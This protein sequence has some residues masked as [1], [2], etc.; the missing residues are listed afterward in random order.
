[1]VTKEE[2]EAS[3]SA[4][5]LWSYGEQFLNASKKLGTPHLPALYLACHGIERA[6]KSH[7]RAKEYS[8]D[9]LIGIRHSI[10]KALSHARDTGMRK[11]PVR[12]AAVLQFVEEIHRDDEYRYPH[13]LV[14]AIEVRYFLL[15]GAWALRA[16]APAVSRSPA[17][18]SL[19]VMRYRSTEL[20]QW[21]ESQAPSR[22]QRQAIARMQKALAEWNERQTE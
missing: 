6:I 20:M 22:Q 9:A 10:A 21:A 18:V 17:S 15:A 2:R 8:L 16:A 19:S 3:T 14:R 12:I 1:M 13:S 7:L 11:P 4:F 5:M